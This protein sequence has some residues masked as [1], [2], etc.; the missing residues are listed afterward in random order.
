M[1]S[2]TREAELVKL[3]NLSKFPI[4]EFGALAY[5]EELDL[6]KY[7]RSED[8]EAVPQQQDGDFANFNKRQKKAIRVLFNKLD[9][10][11]QSLVLQEREI[12]G[13]WQAIQNRVTGE[14]NN[15]NIS[16]TTSKVITKCPESGNVVQHIANLNVQ[17][18]NLQKLGITFP[19]QVK[20]GFLYGTLPNYMNDTIKLLDETKNTSYSKA[21]NSFIHKYEESKSHKSDQV[22]ITCYGCGSEGHIKQNCPRKIPSSQKLFCRYCKNH[23]HEIKQCKILKAKKNKDRHRDNHRGNNTRRG[24]S[25]YQANVIGS[26]EPFVLFTTYDFDVPDL[27]DIDSDSDSDSDIDEISFDDDTD[28][29]EETAWDFDLDCNDFDSSFSNFALMTGTDQEG[30]A[31]PF[32]DSACSVHMWNNKSDFIKY[33]FTEQVCSRW[34]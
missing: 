8:P 4:W 17:L 16:Q 10:N 11:T 23:G 19:D 24:E 30:S 6:E 3:E 5:L 26:T 27:I 7:I 15:T 32:I 34:R 33:T 28:F 9:E 22:L 12:V 25:R 18:A 20:I 31:G 1:Q 14:D 29:D 21:C 2:L 13:F